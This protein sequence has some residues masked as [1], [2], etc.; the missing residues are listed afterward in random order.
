M[1]TRAVRPVDIEP[2]IRLFDVVYPG[3][4]LVD[5]AHLE[6][7][8][9]YTKAI[10][11]SSEDESG[12]Q[13]NYAVLPREFVVQGRT[14]RGSLS[15]DTATR[16]DQRGN[17]LFPQSAEATYLQ[18]TQDQVDFTLGFPNKQS[19]PGFA[20][21]LGFQ[22]I[23]TLPFLIKPLRYVPLLKSIVAGRRSR[24]GSDLSL[25]WEPSAQFRSKHWHA[26]IHSD[27]DSADDFQDLLS[28]IHVD[29]H[30][31]THRS[32]DFFRWRYADCPTRKYTTLVAR[33]SVGGPLQS[34][35]VLRTMEIHGIKAG[36]IVDLG[37]RSDEESGRALGFLLEVATRKF[38]EAGMHALITACTDAS[39]ESEQLYLDGFWSVPTMM[40]PQPLHVILRIHRTSDQDAHLRHFPNWF[41]TFGDYDVV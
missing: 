28:N 2:M 11:T 8:Y 18:L 6:W 12:W 22:V 20:N 36:V 27:E 16:P 1:L 13:S 4:E 5:R 39:R 3:S 34:Y 31:H 7:K 33:S 35:I 15:V 17:G 40:L 32:P 10:V 19:M 9:L 38:R 29:Y 41:L 25:R 14:K 26:F 37:C 24:K 23:G 30:C 21:R